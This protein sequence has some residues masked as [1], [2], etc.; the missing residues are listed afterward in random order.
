MQNIKNVIK[1]GKYKGI[2]FDLDGTIADTVGDITNSINLMRGTYNLDNVTEAMVLEHI[3]L[4][5][6]NV[7]AGVLAEKFDDRIRDEEELKAALAVYTQFYI[8]HTVEK[9]YAYPGMEELLENLCERGFKLC[10]LSNKQDKLTKKIVKTLFSG[11]Y[12]TEVLGASEYFSHKPNPASALYLAEK[13]QLSCDEII[14]VGD[15]N[16]DMETAKNANMFPVGVNWGYR[17]RD[18]LEQAGAMLII[19]KPDDLLGFLC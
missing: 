2:I 13:M 14:F 7:I 3:N 5:A 15:S 12:F 9:T 6:I 18:I 11:K 16:V 8:D 10:V 17:S 19:E 4:G 1:N